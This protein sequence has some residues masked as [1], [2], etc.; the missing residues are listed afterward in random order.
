MLLY[1]LLWHFLLC[2]SDSFTFA[3]TK[4]LKLLNRRVLLKW[5]EIGE[6][7]GSATSTSY[8]HALLSRSDWQTIR[9]AGYILG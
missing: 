9:S 6:V 5:W 8:V 4:S 7:L 3:R 1:V 2:F